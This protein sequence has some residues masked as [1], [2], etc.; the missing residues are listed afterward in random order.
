[1]PASY[2]PCYA[3]SQ[4]AMIRVRRHVPSALF[5]MLTACSSRGLIDEVWCGATAPEPVETSTAPTYHRDIAPIVEARCLSCHAPG[6]PG[7]HDLT[8]QEVVTGLAP[9]IRHKVANREM[10]PW[11]PEQCCTPYKYSRALEPEEMALID[12]WANNGAPI[13]DPS[14]RPP[15]M[16]PQEA[17]LSRVDRTLEMPEPYTPKVST[18]S[19]LDEQRCFLLD[20]PSDQVEYVTGLN[21]RP[22]RVELVHHVIVYAA[23]ADQLE[24]FQ[25]LDGEDP[26][27]GWDCYG[28]VGNRVSAGL[29][30]WAPGFRGVD[31]PAGTGQKMEPD[32]KIVLEVHYHAHAG[33]PALAD[34]TR[35]ELALAPAVDR[36]AKTILVLH[37]QWLVGDGLRIRAGEKDAAWAFRY[38]PTAYEDGDALELHNITLHM[39]ALGT[40]GRVMIERKD[41]GTEC[42]I[43]ISRW[44]YNWQGEYW[45]ET[46]KIL[47]EGDR[48]YLECHWDNSAEGAKDLAWGNDGEMCMA[49]LYAVPSLEGR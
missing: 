43:E 41:G 44:D 45:F 5:F 46:P 14:Q 22:E 27:P 49:T 1:M 38:D 36:E 39:H 30:G 24:Y 34:R 29:G 25:A 7:G 2:R 18:G 28:G 3:R 31:F 23:D 26:A 13:G 10:P 11:P 6:G 17:G 21:V 42:L 8:R 40:R 48:I 35:V 37:P 15:S 33:V 16:P 9:L 19:Q 32:G 47:R 4:P 12:R 20:W